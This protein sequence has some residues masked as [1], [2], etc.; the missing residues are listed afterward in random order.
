LGTGEAHSVREL[1]AAACAVAG[2]D[3]AE[4]V[5]GWEDAEPPPVGSV[6]PPGYVG[7]DSAHTN[8]AGG[9]LPGASESRADPSLAWRELGWEAGTKFAA[10]V[11]TLTKYAL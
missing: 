8:A 4:Y 9:H 5:A 2:I 11:E 3:P 10:L 6:R 1:V 7:N